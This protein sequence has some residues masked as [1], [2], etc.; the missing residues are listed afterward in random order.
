MGRFVGRHDGLR[1]W[2]VRSLELGK[3]RMGDFTFFLVGS[4]SEAN[5]DAYC[6]TYR[7]RRVSS[8]D[9]CSFALRSEKL[10]FMQ[11]LRIPDAIRR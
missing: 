11:N 4:G 10:R 7:V 6:G 9:G 5:N 1:A 3:R 2:I 8:G